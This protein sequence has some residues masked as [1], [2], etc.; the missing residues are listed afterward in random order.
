MGKNYFLDLCNFITVQ[1]IDGAEFS[2]NDFP[3]SPEA[4]VGLVFL[5][6]SGETKDL[7]RC[8]EIGRRRNAFLLG[9]VNVVDSMI[10][11]EVDCGCYLNSGREVAV[12]STKSFT[13][14]V[15]ILNLMAIYFAQIHD[16]SLSKRILYIKYLRNLAQDTKETLQ[17]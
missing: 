16:I 5:S 7:H 2:E 17:A 14:Q 11:R 15:I 6:Q 8:V 1:V 4:K 3:R 10:S 13:S 9:V 12:A